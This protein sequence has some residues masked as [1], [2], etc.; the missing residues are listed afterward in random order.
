[1]LCLNTW[2]LS[3]ALFDVNVPTETGGLIKNELTNFTAMRFKLI[4]NIF[5]RFFSKKYRNV[6]LNLLQ[7]VTIVAIVNDFVFNF[8][9]QSHYFP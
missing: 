3:V 1:M 9:S 5:Q 2:C 7:Y 6:V 8:I 4:C